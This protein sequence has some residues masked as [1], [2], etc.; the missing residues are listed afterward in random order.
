[1]TFRADHVAHARTTALLTLALGWPFGWCGVA[2]ALALGLAREGAQWATA[3]WAWL[4]ALANR[5]TV[6]RWAMV[7]NAEWSDMVANGAGALP[8]VVVLWFAGRFQ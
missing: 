6:T 3:R 5:W 7:G 2:A 4:K 1:M 8:V